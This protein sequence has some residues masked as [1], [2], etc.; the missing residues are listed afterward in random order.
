MCVLSTVRGMSWILDTFTISRWWFPESMRLLP[1]AS[2]CERHV[3]VPDVQQLR[4]A[5]DRLGAVG[6]RARESLCASLMAAVP[7]VSVRHR[8]G[9]ESLRQGWALE[10]LWRRNPLQCHPGPRLQR[11]RA[12]HQRPLGRAA[13]EKCHRLPPL[14]AL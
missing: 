13:L 6:L 11:S 8:G 10:A 9:L 5:N 2:E 4:G 7:F 3:E 14:D 1:A 12:L